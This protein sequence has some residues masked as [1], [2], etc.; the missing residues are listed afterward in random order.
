[1]IKDRQSVGRDKT[2]PFPAYSLR[3]Q[4]KPNASDWNKTKMYQHEDTPTHKTEYAKLAGYDITGIHTET[5]Q[6]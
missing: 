1:M 5:R 6:R 2:P 4:A 3:Q